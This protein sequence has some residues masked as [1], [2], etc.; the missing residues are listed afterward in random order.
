MLKQAWQRWLDRRLP[1]ARQVQLDQR[2][3]FIFPTGYGFLY[4]LVSVLLFFGG[5]NY[6]NNLILGLCFL[7]VSLFL[8]A[9]LHTFR[10]LSGLSLRAGAEAE[11]ARLPA[12]LA[13]AEQLAGAVLPG[14]HGR[15]R[16]GTGDDFWQYRPAQI[17]DSRRAIDHRRSARGD[18]EFVRE[19]EWQIAQSVMLYAWELSAI[20]SAV[21]APAGDDH[22][23][24][25]L[26]A[27]RERL[28][29]LLPVIDTPADGKLS[30][31]LFEKLPLLSKRDIGFV[32][33]LCSNIARKIDNSS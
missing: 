26:A 6:E 15:R 28:E 8:V 32:H 3:I 16:A 22:D 9:I 19:R 21:T 12:L 23:P 5:I 4:L 30:Q 10:N 18:Q 13:R 25:R 17:G 1:R 2:R 14:A 33:T 24:A 31:W 27:L 7:M 11:A 20:K 29:Q